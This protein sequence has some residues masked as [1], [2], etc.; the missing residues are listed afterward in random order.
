MARL[1]GLLQV[2]EDQKLKWGKCVTLA[3]TASAS[4]GAMRGYWS[5][6]TTEAWGP[7]VFV[8]TPAVVA[9]ALMIVLFKIHEAETRARLGKRLV[10]SLH[11]RWFPDEFGALDQDYSVAMFVPS[12]NKE[13]PVH[14]RCLAKS[15]GKRD[16]C[17][18]PH[19]AGDEKL[20]NNGPVPFVA[21][22]H[23]D[24]DIC[25]VLEASREDPAEIIRYFRSAKLSEQDNLARSWPFA[26]ISVKFARAE[27]GTLQVIMEVQRKSGHPVE[28]RRLSC[29]ANLGNGSAPPGTA[30]AAEFQLAAQVAAALWEG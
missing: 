18:C 1:E 5:R 7:I 22:K 8:G 26:S 2:F 29:Q 14:W 15:N 16:T 11:E 30:F 10:E 12:P 23:V 6:L 17:H 21:C 24:L 4:I 27:N 9:I 20:R 13:K 25:G 19:V 28:P 3:A